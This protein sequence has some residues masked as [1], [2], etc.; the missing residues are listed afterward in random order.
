MIGTV[1]TVHSLVHSFTNQ[2]QIKAEDTNPV[3]QE[4]KPMV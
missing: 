3:K 4:V 1:R 2:V